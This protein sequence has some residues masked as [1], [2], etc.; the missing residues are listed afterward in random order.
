MLGA[1][2]RQVKD[3]KRTSLKN[4]LH[5]SNLQQ[6]LWKN[7]KS[8]RTTYKLWPLQIGQRERQERRSWWED[9]QH[10]WHQSAAWSVLGPKVETM[11]TGP[12]RSQT[13]DCDSQYS[14]GCAG[15]LVIELQQT[16]EWVWRHHT[17]HWEVQEPAESWSAS[18]AQEN[19]D[20][21]LINYHLH[22]ICFHWW[23][24]LT[25]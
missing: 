19:A 18:C 25:Y 10:R 5:L 20:Q 9:W 21:V 16:S 2:A 15:R 11:C 12:G 17:V 7:R 23:K 13:V 6:W 3:L 14:V 1:N 8:E 4:K 24:H 22:W